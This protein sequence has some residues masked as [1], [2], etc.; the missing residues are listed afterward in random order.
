MFGQLNQPP[1]IVALKLLLREGQVD[2]CVI[3]GTHLSVTSVSN[4]AI[5]GY[6]VI[7][8]DGR[9]G[10]AFGGVPILVS[11][12]TD[13][14]KVEGEPKLRFPH[15]ACSVR[16]FPTGDGG[17]RNR[18]TGVYLPPSAKTAIVEWKSLAGSGG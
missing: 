15:S 18:K 5:K 12:G 8:N 13:A 7:N 11:V 9:T 4:L 16:L 10:G 17:Y 3:T 6:D 2:A 1:S 14:P